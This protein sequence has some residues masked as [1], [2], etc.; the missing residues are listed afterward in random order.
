MAINA[1]TLVMECSMDNA[2]MRRQ[3]RAMDVRAQ[4]ATKTTL[5]LRKLD[6]PC[7]DTKLPGEA[8][9]GFVGQ[10]DIPIP[11]T[12]YA[13]EEIK[14]LERMYSE[15]FLQTI[16]L[17]LLL[18]REVALDDL[19]ACQ[20]STLWKRRSI[21]VD[22]TAFLHSQD[23]A[24]ISRDSEWQAQDR[25]SLQD[26]F[27]ELLGES[28]TPLPQNV[29]PVQGRYF[30][31]KLTPDRRSELEICLQLAQNPLFINLQCSVEVVDGKL[32]HEKRLNMPIDQ[33]PL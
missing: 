12:E 5:N 1:Y 23:V 30:Y 32:G 29:D 2:E 21:D 16:Y 27:T 18:K 4:A 8:L 20:Q 19:A 26:K 22:I 24:R 10:K 14:T 15:T 13:L 9:Q 3:V 31:C 25:Q 17:A 33:L 6:V 28:F 7:A 11:F